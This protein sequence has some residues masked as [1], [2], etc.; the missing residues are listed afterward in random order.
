MNGKKINCALLVIFFSIGAEKLYALDNPTVNSTPESLLVPIPET[1]PQPVPIP[2]YYLWVPTQ[3][4]QIPS[5][6]PQPVPVPWPVIW[7]MPV[8]P[9]PVSI[10]QPI[11][12]PRSQSWGT[13]YLPFPIPSGIPQP[14][15]IPKPVSK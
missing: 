10:P 13:P 2:G 5:A 15:P 6:T 14:V 8:R 1:V 9:A 12:I 4:A 7:V 11:P 3:P